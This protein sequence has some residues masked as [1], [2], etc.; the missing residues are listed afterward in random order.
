MQHPDDS[1]S[2]AEA[3]VREMGLDEALVER[4]EDDPLVQQARDEIDDIVD[5]SKRSG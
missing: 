1:E 2:P 5:R 4:S 3:M